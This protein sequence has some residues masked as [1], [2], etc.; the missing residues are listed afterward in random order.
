MN[1]CHA[2][3]LLALKAFCNHTSSGTEPAGGDRGD[4]CRRLAGGGQAAKDIERLL[5]AGR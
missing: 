1:D 4:A 5:A 2:S 3:N